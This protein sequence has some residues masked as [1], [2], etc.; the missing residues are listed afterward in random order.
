MITISLDEKGTFENNLY[1]TGSIVMIA[2]IVCGLIIGFISML[3]IKYM[4]FFN[5][6]REII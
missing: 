6:K 4:K 3:V 5:R 2:G 1:G